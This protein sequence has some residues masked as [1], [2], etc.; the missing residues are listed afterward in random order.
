M[1]PFEIKKTIQKKKKNVITVENRKEIISKLDTGISGTSIAEE[2]N[3]SESTI[4]KIK[5]NK[6]NVLERIEKFK[7]NVESS[8]KPIDLSSKKSLKSAKDVVLENAVLIWFTQQRNLGHPVSG[9]LLREKAL[10]LHKEL[11]GNSNFKAS[12]GWLHRFCKRNDIKEYTMK[13][14]S[15]SADHEAAEEY[16]KVRTQSYSKV[17]IK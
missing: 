8:P 3:V 15:L 2:Y 17:K 16:K 11:N 7:K 1:K 13:G 6:A 10:E 5:K 12:S 14:E 9:P 4:S